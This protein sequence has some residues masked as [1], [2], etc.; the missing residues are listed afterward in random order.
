MQRRQMLFLAWI[1]AVWFAILPLTTHAQAAATYTLKPEYFRVADFKLQSGAVLKEMVVEY[2][3]LGEPRRDGSG[4]IVNAVINPHGWSGNF[5]QSVTIAKDMVGPGTPLDPGKYFIIFPT[6]LGS[7]GSSSPAVSGLGPRFPRYTVADMVA[8]QYRLVTEKFGIRKLA[9]VIGASMGG[10]QTLQWITQ[11]PDMMGWAVP[12]AA[13]RKH[14][15][16][17]LGIFGMMSY[18]I[19][20]DPA[21]MNGEYKEQPKDGMRRGFMGTYLWYFGTAFYDAQYKTEE[22]ALKG[23]QD[24][25]LGSD[26]MDANDI[27]WRNLA[28]ASYD[29]TANLSKVKAKVLV[30]GVVEDELFPPKEAIQP[31]ADAIPSTKVFLYESPLGHL[32]CAVHIGKANAAIMQHIA[33]AEKN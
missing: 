32:G 29:V 4:N 18:N 33:E 21:Y 1:A 25:G 13:S 5:A 7:P 14:D 22:Q 28:M 10:Y 9:G 15:G 24:A 11:Y 6:A 27:I 26:K 8:A 16:R 30:V 19:R 31:I 3:T 2:A 20:T 17:N 23:L 12:I